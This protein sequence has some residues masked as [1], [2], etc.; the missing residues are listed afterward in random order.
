MDEFRFENTLQLTESQYL[1]V[2]AILPIWRLS[3]IVRFGV[4]VAVAV[5]LLF[6][7]Y[8]LLLGLILL[9]LAVLALLA[10]RIVPAGARSTFRQHKYLRDAL[11][12][13]VSDQR[14]WVKGAKIDAR[15]PWSMLV[16]WREKEDWLVLSPSGIPPVYL[17]LARLRE[18][19]LYGRVR[20][21]AASNA[22]EFNKSDPRASP[23]AR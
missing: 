22:P 2:W 7:M 9:G 13:G 15:V 20:A 17:S 14:L 11:T 12:Y 18:E 1:A 23:F 16:T 3:R 5:V 10:P 6:T 8:T 19:G 21:L 4:L